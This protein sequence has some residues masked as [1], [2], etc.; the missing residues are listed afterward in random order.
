[1][2]FRNPSSSIINVSYLNKEALKI[3]EN[4]IY[5]P[6]PQKKNKCAESESAQK[7]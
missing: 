3:I 2:P 5:S 7:L 1:M 4:K 6:P